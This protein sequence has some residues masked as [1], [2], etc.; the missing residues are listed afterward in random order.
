MKKKVSVEH[1]Q[2]G[3][4]IHDLNCGWVEHPFLSNR[5]LIMDQHAIEQIIE[6]GIQEVY[7]DTRKGL[8]VGVGQSIEHVNRELDATIEKVA[9]GHLARNNDGPQETQTLAHQGFDKRP[10]PVEFKEE[11]GVARRIRTEANDVVVHLLHD[12]RM[13][14]RVEAE[15]LEVVV[16]DMI[17]S[18][19]RNQN[20]LLSLGR[21]RH[22]DRYTFEHSVN[23]AALL[24]AF[25]KTLDFD[26]AT[27]RHIGT[28]ALLHDLGKT[29]VPESILNKPDKLTNEEFIIMKRH[30]VYSYEILSR[31]PDINEIALQVAAQHH[32]RYD[33]TGY[34]HRLKG[35]SISLFGQMAAI[36]DVYDAITSDRCY[37]KGEPPT[38]VLRKMLEWSKHHFEPILVQ[39]FIQCVGIYPPGTMVRLKNDQL[40][41]VLDINPQGLLNPVVK[42]IYDTRERSYIKPKVIDLS[43]PENDLYGVKSFEDHRDWG[44]PAENFIPR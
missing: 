7:I 39:K 8:D 42:V 4:Y 28:G 21:I 5:F 33:G 27:I 23:V 14:K 37:H 2:E 13:G 44:I 40:A 9:N 34:P 38:V 24:I 43:L 41:I 35:E 15:R 22:M 12:A 1:L 10:D 26:M 32:E 16:E 20:A 17:G 18:I 29:R 25:A 36:V 6:L 3:M 31:T 11:V 30:V 19:F